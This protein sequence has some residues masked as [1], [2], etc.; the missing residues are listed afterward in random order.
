MIIKV[1]VFIVACLL[2]HVRYKMGYKWSHIF[3]P[4]RWKAV[5][6]WFLKKELKRVAPEENSFLLTPNDLL[7]IANRVAMCEPCVLNGKCLSCNCD[8]GGAMSDKN[9]SC[10]EGK[11]GPM[12]TEEEMEI[13]KKEN[14]Y[15]Y[16]QKNI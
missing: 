1:I 7:Q 2:L 13:L 10:S 9:L 15:N 14:S 3:S 5:Y 12:K 4:T 16:K 11:W 6:K 8:I